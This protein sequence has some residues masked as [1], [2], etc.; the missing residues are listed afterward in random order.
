MRKAMIYQ[1]GAYI[2]GKPTAKTE[3]C[4]GRLHGFS[5]DYEESNGQ[6]GNYPVAIIE[7]PDGT[8]E[9]VPLAL[10]QLLEEEA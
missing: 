9:G 6:I 7:L 2:P 4:I 3:R 1:W 10:V 8:L 5:T